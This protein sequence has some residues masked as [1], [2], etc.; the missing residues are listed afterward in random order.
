[1]TILFRVSAGSYHGEHVSFIKKACNQPLIHASGL[2]AVELYVGIDDLRGVLRFAYDLLASGRDKAFLTHSD[3]RVK[4][5]TQEEAG[6]RMDISR[7]TVWRLL[8]Q[9]R[10]KTAQALTEG[11]PL[12]IVKEPR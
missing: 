2:T 9:V 7:G 1:M 11:R 3:T 8:Q 10:R 12:Q 5:S 6:K 4:C